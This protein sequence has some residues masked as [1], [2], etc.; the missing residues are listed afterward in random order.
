MF[1]SKELLP[2]LQSKLTGNKR[3]GHFVKFY[4]S[5]FFLTTALLLT[6][7]SPVHAAS[8][9]L[10]AV[11]N[12]M[13]DA[14]NPTIV[15]AGGNFFSTGQFGGTQTNRGLLLFDISSLG[16][17]W[18]INSVTLNLTV[19]ANFLGTS[20]TI[21]IYRLKQKWVSYTSTSNDSTPI[22]NASYNNYRQTLSLAWATPGAGD[23]TNDRDAAPIGSFNVTSATTGTVSVTLD[24][25]MVQ[26]WVNGTYL[27]NGLLLQASNETD[28]TLMRWDTFS[29]ST[30]AY[31][32]QLVINYTPVTRTLTDNLL[33][34][35][36]MDETSGNLTDS[37][38]NGHTLTQNNSPTSTTGILGNAQHYV[39][40][41]SQYHS[42]SDAVLKQG[43]NDWT[44]AGWVWLTD[45]TNYYTIVGNEDNRY[46]GDV[47][48]AGWSLFYHKV[49]I[50]D[51]FVFQIYGNTAGGSDNP[52][53]DVVGTNCTSPTP[54][55]AWVFLAV[56][57]DSVRHIAHLFCNNNAPNFAGAHNSIEGGAAF[58]Y[59]GT[60]VAS[61]GDFTIGSLPVGPSPNGYMNGNIDEVGFWNRWLSNSEILLLYNSGAGLSYPFGQAPST[62]SSS[63]T[64][65]STTSAPSCGDQA[66]GTKAPWIYSAITQ[67]SSSVL[68]YFTE[69][70]NPVNKY[71]LEYGTKSGDYSFGVQDMGVNSRGP[72]TFLVK[73]LS[74]HTTYYFRVR[75][76]NGCAT[77]AWSNEISATTKGL[78]TTNTLDIVSSELTPVPSEEADT[79][80]QTD[81]YEVKVKVTDAQNKPIA[82]AQVTLHSNP[83]TA[84]TDK[85]GIAHFQNVEPGEHRVTI[86]YT[87]HQGEQTVNLTGEVKEFELNIQIKPVNPFLAPPVMA[88]IG[89]LIL[90]IIILALRKNKR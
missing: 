74:P 20:H 16:T 76:G 49:E 64:T 39:S 85:D 61:T 80:P 12:G 33:A 69:A 78:V 70:D 19:S 88:V 86:A 24:P 25:T 66:P 37:S 28:T 51:N 9:T 52:I 77:G 23:T 48:Y 36:K 42:N 11:T 83:Q 65:S 26:S 27:N 41:S 32:P 79:Q 87:N 43:N 30:A 2:T 50:L 40:S 67:D 35:W 15:N 45:K 75:G 38:G 1:C 89:L 10:T 72:M 6:V 54:S 58:T 59:P 81:G 21:N 5:L 13:I 63:T 71:V 46:F 82:G 29:N 53:A 7:S 3:L 90:A 18:T 47:Q 31:R 14:K 34:Y 56:R 22:D 68:L 73:S 57:N 44:W 17:D 4:F 55:G 84:T 60:F 62:S 8:T